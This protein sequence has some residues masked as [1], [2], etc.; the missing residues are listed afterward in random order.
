MT[1]RDLASRSLNKGL[2]V[3]GLPTLTVDLRTFETNPGERARLSAEASGELAKLFFAHHGRRINKWIH[4]LDIYDSHFARFRNTPVKMLEI[5]VYKGGSLELWR[6]YFGAEATIFGIDI[7]PECANCVTS[8]N[9]VRIGSQDDPRFLRSVINEIG[10]P[11]IILDD[12]AHNGRCQRI[13]F[14]ELFPCL[15]EGGLYVIEDLHT[16]YMPGADEGGYRR[17]G[18]GI[19]FIKELIDDVH[20][21]YHNK[22]THA[23]AKNSIGA[24]HVYDSM[25]VIE[26]RKVRRPSYIMVE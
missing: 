19:E 5:G 10:A 20:V 16:S 3:A 18:T 6:E 11:N 8:P 25:V 4:Y 2:R 21:W 7:D 17:G 15:Q 1:L 24:I 23:P 13:S 14:N 12:G 26:K 22:P 9:Q